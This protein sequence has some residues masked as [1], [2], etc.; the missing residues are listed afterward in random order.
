VTLR[1]GHRG[2]AGTA[3]ENTLVSM[4]RA[5]EIGVDAVEF[6]IHRTKDGVLVVMHD[7]TVDRTTGGTGTIAD[8]TLA[9]L[10]QLETGSWKGAE[11]AGE[12]MP[13][14][15]ELVQAVPAPVVFFLEVKA[16]SYRYPGIEEQLVAF[17]QE[18][19]MLD[20][21]QVS[22]FDHIALLKLRELLPGLPTGMLYSERPVDPVA[23]A[24]ACGATAIHPHWAMISREVV[25]AAHTAGLQVNVYTP[26]TPAA[27]AA[28]Y[29]MGVDGII[30]DYPERL[31]PNA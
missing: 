4:R 19:G 1:I 8:M 5:L 18:H 21:V 28:C 12:G 15:A 30:T 6:D 24:K 13:T 20:R 7:F 29:A 27:I 31:K 25:A 14:L 16:G 26:N 23:M 22:S 3:P 2:A 10:R 11:F 17:F 9:E